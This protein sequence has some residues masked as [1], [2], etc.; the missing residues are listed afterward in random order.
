V[1]GAA[2][3]AAWFVVLDVAQGRLFFTPAALGSALFLGAD[4]PEAAQVTLGL[5]AAFTIVHVAAFVAL[6]LVATAIV[7]GV[8]RHPPVILGAVLLFVTMQTF[9]IGLIAITA[10]WLV[11]ALT[12]WSIGVANLLA[13]VVMGGYLW[14]RHPELQASL[15][16]DDLEGDQPDVVIERAGLRR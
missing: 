9:L 14:R 11:D 16:Q 10:T 13:A 1:L 12:W 6:G 3:V 7:R 2:T 15:R 5:I 8:R 4:S